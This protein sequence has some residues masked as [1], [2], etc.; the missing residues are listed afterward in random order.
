MDNF[1]GK[2]FASVLDVFHKLNCI[3]TKRQKQLSIV[4][5][6]M[7][8]VGAA[9]ETLGVSV[10]IP[11]V[12]S[13][14]E[15]DELM[16]SEKLR[17]FVE[18]L[19]ISSPTQMIM[20][21]AGAVILA[22]VV[23]NA[24]MVVLSYVRAR[25]ATKVKRELSVR[26]MHSYMER[27]YGYFLGVN[28]ADVLR[29]VG[30]DVSGVHEV[31]VQLF[32]IMAES[33]SA[34]CIC[35]F[36][37]YQDAIM[38]MGVVLLMGVSLSALILLFRKRMK[39]V[40]DWYRDCTVQVNKYLYESFQGIKD[41]LVFHKEEY[42]IKN[43]ENAFS[44]QQKADVS[45]TVASES[46][47]YLIEAV[48]VGGLILVVSTKIAFGGD[49]AGFVPLLA[50]FAVAAFRILPSI[51]KISAAFN[52]LVCACPAMNATYRNLQEAG[53]YAHAGKVPQG[54]EYHLSEKNEAFSFHREIRAE[55]IY[56]KY[57]N[58]DRFVIENL[59]LVIRKGTSTAFIGQSGAGKSTMADILLGLFVP[60]KGNILVDG[61]S[62]YQNMDAWKKIVGYV[63]QSV[64]LTDDT[65]RRNI[66]FGVEEDEIE[67]ERIRRAVE[68]A[69]LTSTVRELPD[70]LDTI[71]GE[72]GIRFSGGQKQRVA[73]ARA[74]YNDPEILILDE[75]TAALDND[76]ENAVMEAI[77]ALHGYKTLIIIAHRLST[78]Q[79]CDIIFEIGDGIA[80]KRDKD[81]VLR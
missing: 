40:G 56:W 38:A 79:N 5:F 81:E 57:P 54:I 31:L 64:F 69:Q 3:L 67:E 55:G 4:V 53:T 13:F 15:A 6:F 24:Y 36:I 78:I 60:E 50:A 28:T 26:I 48:C 30:Y 70:G 22:Y 80:R 34:V 25:F 20:W 18:F 11:L 12:Q 14:L 75:A 9:L 44:N 76:T 74:L 73:I 16:R 1:I 19:N 52:Q 47:A 42:F 66:A 62:I 71:M 58:S 8:V 41:V 33:L 17:P 21:I 45:R 7:T 29:G 46:P 49:A 23:K 43:Y 37:F 2:D 65:I 63:P 39:R 35:I 32:R 51:G 72:R 59:N 10:I 61:R 77:D 27:E 68:Q